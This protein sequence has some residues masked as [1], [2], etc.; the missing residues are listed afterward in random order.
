MSD[1]VNLG[2]AEC[3]H[4]TDLAIKCTVDDMDEPVWIPKSQIHDNSEVYK[5]G[6]EGDLIVTSWLAKQQGWE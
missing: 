3:T 5:K 4:E 2:Q 6:H 1:P